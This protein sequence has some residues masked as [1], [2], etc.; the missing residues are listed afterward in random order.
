MDENIDGVIEASKGRSGL[1]SPA[2]IT[3]SHITPSKLQVF[4]HS[5]SLGIL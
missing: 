2:K 3:S 4:P 5:M 1:A